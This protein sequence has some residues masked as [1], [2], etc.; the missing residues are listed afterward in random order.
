MNWCLRVPRF[1]VWD[2]S[3]TFGS[4]GPSCSLCLYSR[5]FTCSFCRV[6]CIVESTCGSF[7]FNCYG[8]AA[9]TLLCLHL[10]EDESDTSNHRLLSLL[11][12]LSYTPIVTR[13]SMYPY[14][15]YRMSCLTKYLVFVF[16]WRALHDDRLPSL[17]HFAFLSANL[18]FLLP[19]F[20]VVL[21][22]NGLISRL[23]CL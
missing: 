7:A 1:Q 16:L 2:E 8:M 4:V 5:V 11:L 6:D 23:P 22:L 19:G 12:G 10:E 13:I 14:H 18:F 20:Q 3:W 15:W 21:H 9:T 17:V